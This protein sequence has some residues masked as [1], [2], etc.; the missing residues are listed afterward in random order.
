MLTCE[1]TREQ[2]DDML[3]EG[4]K[5][6][7][8]IAAHLKTCDDCREHFQS[9]KE[10]ETRL[11][12]AARFHAAELPREAPRR[13]LAEIEARK[14]RRVNFWFY[15]LSAACLLA[16][17]LAIGA[18]FVPQPPVMVGPISPAPPMKKMAQKTLVAVAEQEPQALK[19]ILTEPDRALKSEGQKL[20]TDVKSVQSF[21]IRCVAVSNPDDRG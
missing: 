20:L 11:R 16:L 4:E 19:V 15:G 10:L 18:H 7:G 17:A 13:A 3:D 5:P 6:A 9:L 21:L 14:P 2:L 1:Q 8:E 12:G